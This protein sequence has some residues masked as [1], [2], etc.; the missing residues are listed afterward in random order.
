MLHRPPALLLALA[1]CATPV[2]AADSF[3]I[4]PPRQPGDPL[5]PG[6]FLRVIERVTGLASP[7]S[8]VGS[9]DGTNRLFIIEQGGRIRIWNGTTLLPTPFLDIS[10]LITGG[11][12]TEQGLLG[13]AF[14]P[15]YSTNG[16]FYVNY[17]C[18]S[19]APAC[20]S[21]GFGTGDAV[22]ARYHVSANPNVAD[23]AS[24]QIL[25]VID[26]PFSNHN[27]GN[28]AFG[29][30]GYLYIGL[31]DGGS[32]DDECEYAQNLLW[33]FTPNN[34]TAACSVAT[35]RANHR[36]FWGKMLR[37]DVNQNLNTPP[38]YGIPPT[39]PYTSANDPTDLIPDEIWAYGLRNPWRY[40]FDRVNG[41]LYIGDVGQNTREEIDRLVA[42]LPV[43]R[44]FGWDVLEGFLCHEDVPMGS[45][46]SFLNGGSVL[47]A[48]TMS[49]S[50]LRW[51]ACIATTPSAASRKVSARPRLLP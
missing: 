48:R 35:S 21:G 16:Y 13:L 32:G 9:N 7:I 37:L 27:G 45:C 38:F 34:P 51:Q 46:N 12:G 4:T 17:T 23:P 28:L 40:S 41:D 43:G 6:I 24:A 31:G 44:N 29:P 15:S 8:V 30:D 49:A 33:V 10:G 1:L 36:T 26:D 50:R 47:P 19:A 22:I 18:R 5:A 2:L 42:P 25:T 20:S 3:D 39:N 11:P 14:H